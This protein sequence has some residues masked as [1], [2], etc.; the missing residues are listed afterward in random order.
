MRVQ[1][2]V[3][4]RELAAYLRGESEDLD[5]YV[6][7]YRLYG[8]K[9]ERLFYF[10][11]PVCVEVHI[12]DD[13]QVYDFRQQ[14]VQAARESLLRM[15]ELEDLDWELEQAL[16]WGSLY[17]I[18]ASA[19]ISQSWLVDVLAGEPI[20]PQP[21]NGDGIRDNDLLLLHVPHL[22]GPYPEPRQLVVPVSDD[23]QLLRWLEI[24]EEGTAPEGCPRLWG[25]LLYTMAD[26]SLATYVRTHFDDLNA[27]SGPG[28][29]IFVV[30]RLVNHHTTRRFWRRHLEP[31]LFRKLS[32]TRLLSWRPF[33]PQGAY[34]IAS[35][36][37]IEP[38]LLPCLVFFHGAITPS[39]EKILFR[40]EDSSPA[41]FRSLFGGITRALRSQR[42]QQDPES[43]VGIRQQ[44]PEHLFL[45]SFDNAVKWERSPQREVDA[46]AF[47]RVRAAQDAIRSALVPADE[48]PPRVKDQGLHIANSR[49][50]VVSG[51]GVTE[52][53]YFQ[54]VNTT[55]INRP[56]S[57]VIRDFQNTYHAVVGA[58]DLARL[59]QL[60]LNSSDLGDAQREE[61]AG[62][63]HDLA[64]ASAA[65]TPD[66]PHMRTRMER[67]RELM[68]G[69]GADI[70]QPA[71]AIL[72][73]LAAL[74]GA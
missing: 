7:W 59:L 68:T 36:V 71:L 51:D 9:R 16:S 58:D 72:A 55:F 20:S 21:F 23:R 57:T 34:Q 30:E 25:L 35:L 65:Q 6:Q 50:V 12:P 54:G 24:A 22:P 10:R 3:W 17:R 47:S 69:T 13:G 74:F 2:I 1:I 29:R 39:T 62:C 64:R 19:D 31:E 14:V 46:A 15:G 60:V 73:S 49:V 32:A 28:T 33:D 44:E 70:A 41:Y 63:I 11:H 37:G 38:E 42:P 40:I 18:T 52:N 48:F 26:V 43:L 53:F 61:A 8:A 4:S 66:V 67:L 27:L 56:T 45:P 5:R